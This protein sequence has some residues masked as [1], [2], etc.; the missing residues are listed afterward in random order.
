MA[1]SNQAVL[2]RYSYDP[3]DRLASSSPTGQADIQR[4]YQKN[5]LATEIQ[6]ALRRTVFQHEDLLLAQQRRVDG[7][8]ETT[9][10]ATDQQRSV[11]QLVDNTGVESVAYSPYGHHPAESGLTSLLGFNGERR[12]PVTGYYLL[13]NGYRA[14]NPVLMRFN[15]PDSLSPFDEGGL[16]AYGYVGGDPVGFGDPTGHIGAG[17]LRKL[18]TN[19]KIIRKP[20]QSPLSRLS[21]MVDE[22]PSSSTSIYH[23]ISRPSASRAAVPSPRTPMTSALQ[24]SV[25]GRP[26][27]T[28]PHMTVEYRLQKTLEFSNPID[29]TV[30]ASFREAEVRLQQHSRRGIEVGEFVSFHKAN[31]EV[32]AEMSIVAGSSGYY[33]SIYSRDNRNLESYKASMFFKCGEAIHSAIRKQ[34]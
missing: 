14:Y 28:F 25:E 12:D 19:S 11:L 21:K 7:V 30:P 20:K 22:L 13:G 26:T 17:L 2:C 10:L 31:A 27:V 16:N 3:L 34:N 1:S 18:L 32:S 4:F 33:E 24:A 5:R 29:T 23:D 8:L 6:G 9:L 15:S